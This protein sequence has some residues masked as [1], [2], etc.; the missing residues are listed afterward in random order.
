M[1]SKVALCMLALLTGFAIHPAWSDSLD[2]DDEPAPTHSYEVMNFEGRYC[3]KKLA[4]IRNTVQGYLAGPDHSLKWLPYYQ[5]M[6]EMGRNHQDWIEKNAPLSGSKN[7]VSPSLTVSQLTQTVSNSLIKVLTDN[8]TNAEWEYYSFF[9]VHWRKT[10][11]PVYANLQFGYHKSKKDSVDKAATDLYSLLDSRGYFGEYWPVQSNIEYL[12]SA[13]GVVHSEFMQLRDEFYSSKELN[14]EG[15]ANLHRLVKFISYVV[16][17][18][19]YEWLENVFQQSGQQE[20][21]SLKA[22]IR[23][24]LMSTSSKAV[25]V[26]M[27]WL[28]HPETA[29][30]CYNSW[31][32]TVC[33]LSKQ[34][35]ET[36]EEESFERVASSTP[37]LYETPRDMK[38]WY[39]LASKNRDKAAGAAYQFHQYFTTR[40][41]AEYG[42]QDV[43]GVRDTGPW[44]GFIGGI[45][46]TQPF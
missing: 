42:G 10:N 6:L 7:T 23:Q 38:Y 37:K 27:D 11:I 16:V 2:E 46:V 40:A 28:R 32:R 1:K 25:V 36:A 9:L 18:H 43:D 12:K 15:S 35:N 22:E 21:Q 17:A 24:F 20:M 31:F 8:F 39:Q 29:S 14:P 3:A 19:N 45:E 33:R 4:L 26:F 5:F 30:A 41:C 34:A 13:L 44:S